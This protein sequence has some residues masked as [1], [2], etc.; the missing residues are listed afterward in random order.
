MDCLSNLGVC[1]ASCCTSIS[2]T[3]KN[4]TPDLKKYYEYHGCTVINQFRKGWKV[5]VPAKCKHL[6]DDYKCGVHGTK[7]KPDVCN[8]LNEKT[9][10]KYNITEG[11]ILK[12]MLR[13]KKK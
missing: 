13:N 1:K 8:N 11:C 10:H 7:E 4:L 3:V 12:D 9:A 2:F 5:V 6:T